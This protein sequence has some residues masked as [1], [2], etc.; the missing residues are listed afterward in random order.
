[1][2]AEA[3]AVRSALRDYEDRS[4]PGAFPRDVDETPYDRARRWLREDGVRVEIALPFRAMAV[5]V[6]EAVN[7]AAK[8]IDLEYYELKPAVVDW[9]ASLPGVQSGWGEDGAFYLCAPEV[10]AVIF[11]D[12]NE[13]IESRGEW[14]HPWSGIVRQGYVFDV[15]AGDRD[16]LAA[17]AKETAPTVSVYPG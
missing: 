16:L 8:A 10:G 12:P 15:L 2:S 11:H 7:A 1:M 4:V 17:L 3:A 5:L 6:A 13:E 9:V 14:P